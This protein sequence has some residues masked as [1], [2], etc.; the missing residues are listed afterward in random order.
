MWARLVSELLGLIRVNNGGR[1]DGAIMGLYGSSAQQ[2]GQTRGVGQ[3]A[4][5]VDVTAGVAR[6]G[7]KATGDSGVRR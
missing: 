1:W 5:F 3:W 6:A 2:R 4:R 7:T